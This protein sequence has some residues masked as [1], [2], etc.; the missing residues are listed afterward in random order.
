MLYIIL[1]H[2]ITHKAYYVLNY[3]MFF[4]LFFGA[5]IGFF[6]GFFLIPPSA[7]ASGYTYNVDTA[8]SVITDGNIYTLAEDANYVYFGGQFAMVGKPKYSYAVLYNKTTNQI[9]HFIDVPNGEVHTIYPDGSGGWYIGGEFTRVGAHA[10]Q[11]LA[12]IKSDRTVNA[13][14]TPNPNDIVYTIY[15]DAGNV[16]VGGKFTQIGGQ[17]VEYLA[18]VSA[19]TGLPDLTWNT[20]KPETGPSI[21]IRKIVRDGS[22]L[23][24]NG[25]FSMI[26]TTPRLTVAKLDFATGALDMTWNPSL[27]G[28]ANDIA[29]TPSHVYLVGSFSMIQ[30]ALRYYI[31]RTNK[32]TGAADGW[33]PNPN[34]TDI[35]GHVFRVSPN[36]AHNEIYVSGYFNVINGQSGIPIIA[37]LN[38]S[39]GAVDSSWLVAPNYPN[40]HIETIVVSGNTLYLGG[41]FIQINSAQGNGTFRATAVGRTT[42]TK[43]PG[44]TF[45]FSDTVNIM[46]EEGDYIFIG[47]RFL[48]G[49]GT[50]MGNVARFQKSNGQ[51]D[52]GWNPN[53]DNQVNTIAVDSSGV[54]IGGTFFNIGGTSRDRVAKVNTTTGAAIAAWNANLS[55]HNNV[56]TISL[57]SAHAYMGGYFYDGDAYSRYATTTGAQDGSWVETYLSGSVEEMLHTSSGIYIGGNFTLIGGQARNHIARLSVSAPPTADSWN[58][59]ANGAVRAIAVEGSDVFIGGDFT[60]VSSQTR[61]RIAKIDTS[62]ALDATWNVNLDNSVYDIVTTTANVYAVGDFTTANS[63]PMN[64]A[65]KIDIAT[66]DVDPAFTL[67][68]NK[69]GRAILVNKNTIYIAGE[70]TSIK[71]NHDYKHIAKIIYTTPPST[72]P[73]SSQ[74]QQQIESASKNKVLNCD[75]AKPINPPDLFQINTKDTTAKIYFT[76]TANTNMY[77]I[78]FSEDEKAEKHGS[79]ARLSKEGVQSYD[80]FFLQPDKTYYFKVRAISGCIPSEWSNVMKVKTNKKNNKRTVTKFEMASSES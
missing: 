44:W 31:G 68:L 35:N 6:V 45:N 37:K 7:H 2:L 36:L 64:R 40:G 30:S 17:T 67:N 51:L 75:S 47:G 43:L 14:W 12:H 77:H 60:S 21:Y 20:Q 48:V 10:I 24:I 53:A 9:E 69:R 76:P 1:R 26:G 65:V 50:R 55:D 18:K 15:A 79:L 78:S 70:F 32:T 25:T 13:S 80:V 39:T 4:T 73:S 8:F 38:D 3:S 16:Y 62:G 59:N 74:S 58:P 41:K 56:N 66:G 22:D 11:N 28:G 46:H 54:Y 71:G 5:I 42:A 29:V 61:N 72:F 34:P 52:A 49:D 57:S 23:Y 63:N 33:N 27:N 19:T